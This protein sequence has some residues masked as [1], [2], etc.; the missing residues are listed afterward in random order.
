MND[1]SNNEPSILSVQL[2]TLP[3]FKSN[4]VDSS[5]EVDVVSDVV[6]EMKRRSVRRTCQ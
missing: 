2:G 4:A 3:L 1:T 6:F 5:S